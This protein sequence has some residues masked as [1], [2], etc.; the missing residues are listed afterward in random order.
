MDIAIGAISPLI[1][2]LSGI[3]VGEYTLKYRVRKGIESLVT[4]VEVDARRSLQA[5]EGAT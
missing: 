2:K 3:L 1:P 4:R 5:S